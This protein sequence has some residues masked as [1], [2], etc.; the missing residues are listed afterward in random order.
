[1]EKMKAGSGFAIF[2][3]FFGLAVVDAFRTQDWPEV[4]FWIFM[5]AF[6]LILDT[7]KNHRA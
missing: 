6:F 5:G 4:I 3:I 7:G 2:I 1:M